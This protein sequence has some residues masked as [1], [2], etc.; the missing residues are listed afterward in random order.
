[1][2]ICFYEMLIYRRNNEEIVRV[3]L[4]FCWVTFQT[5]W[6]RRRGLFVCIFHSIDVISQDVSI[7]Q[8][9]LFLIHSILEKMI[10]KKWVIQ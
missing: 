8:I 7:Y 9:T 10:Q 1:M 6:K 5:G 3:G 2:E 4:D